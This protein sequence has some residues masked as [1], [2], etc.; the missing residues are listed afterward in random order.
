MDKVITEPKKRGQT[1]AWRI[2]RVYRALWEKDM[3]NDM[4]KL[5]DYAIDSDILPL[6]DKTD[7]RVKLETLL[8]RMITQNEFR[9]LRRL[10]WDMIYIKNSHPVILNQL[11]SAGDDIFSM[12]LDAVVIS[13]QSRR[14]KHSQTGQSLSF[15]LLIPEIGKNAAFET[16]EDITVAEFSK[17]HLE[18][19]QFYSTFNR[20]RGVK[21]RRMIRNMDGLN[22]NDISFLFRTVHDLKI[23]RRSVD[24]QRFST[25][26]TVSMESDSLQLGTYFLLLGTISGFRWLVDQP[27]MSGTKKA[28]ITD[29]TGTLDFRI[30]DKFLLNSSKGVLNPLIESFFGL[31]VET[32]K[33]R[34]ETDYNGYAL[35]LGYWSLDE[36]PYV[37]KIIPLGEN[38]STENM[39]RFYRKAYLNFRRKARTEVMELLFG[40]PRNPLDE[41]YSADKK[42]A[43]AKEGSWD[44]TSFLKFVNSK[45][46]FDRNSKPDQN[47]EK[48]LGYMF[49]NLDHL[50]FYRSEEVEKKIAHHY[51]LPSGFTC[52]KCGSEIY[53]VSPIT[54]CNL[55]S[56]EGNQISIMMKNS[57]NADSTFLSQSLLILREKIEKLSNCDDLGNFSELFANFGITNLRVGSYDLNKNKIS[58]A[59]TSIIN[60]LDAITGVMINNAV[61]PLAQV[62]PELVN[63]PMQP[64]RL[65][66][67]FGKF[68][69]KAPAVADK[70]LRLINQEKVALVSDQNK[71]YIHLRRGCPLGHQ[72]QDI[73]ENNTSGLLDM[74][75]KELMTLKLSEYQKIQDVYYQQFVQMANSWANTTNE[76]IMRKILATEEQK[77]EVDLKFNVIVK[78]LEKHNLIDEN[79]NPLDMS[80]LLAINTKDVVFLNVCRQIKNG[81]IPQYRFWTHVTKFIMDVKSTSSEYDV[82]HLGVVLGP[83]VLLRMAAL[84]Y[85]EFNYDMI[86]GK[87]SASYDIENKFYENIVRPILKKAIDMDTKRHNAYKSLRT[88]DLSRRT[89]GLL[90]TKIMSGDI[91]T[92]NGADQYIEKIS[93]KL[94]ETLPK[95]IIKSK[96]ILQTY[97]KQDGGKFYV[98][99]KKAINEKNMIST[100]GVKPIQLSAPK[101]VST[102]NISKQ[103]Q[104]HMIQLHNSWK[105]LQE[106]K[107]KTAY[108][109]LYIES[110][111]K[112]QSE[113][114]NL[115]SI[116]MRIMP[117]FKKLQGAN[118]DWSITK[119]FFKS[120]NNLD[121][122]SQENIK[123]M[124][125]KI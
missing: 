17:F 3:R 111:K 75:S 44:K 31:P 16:S 88:V 66:F 89:F 39:S 33:Q 5:V 83:R 52:P 68:G 86:L 14:W 1:V 79:G 81:K 80:H 113:F 118:A 91:Y 34:I 47:L 9:S 12:D 115:I 73:A 103:F 28:Q 61:I 119:K 72:I 96:K 26:S 109:L 38:L 49:I 32:T 63:G 42:W 110:K 69:S 7:G 4:Q 59:A 76:L 114:D 45:F 2:Y 124:L 62:T 107:A 35:I 65:V 84:K 55:L 46:T 82:M 51:H 92:L 99:D 87:S 53:S 122:Y 27:E 125:E 11:I 18:N 70:T 36:D 30:E 25:V 23:I 85:V 57:E 100:K 117:S 95:K 93:L 74:I 116:L 13:A 15:N 22:L 106:S 64:I 123:I 102:E 58:D 56:S 121:S 24:L 90:C 50:A 19:I 60:A 104:G 94:G 78:A 21:S 20:I 120:I 6:V 112:F 97:Q 29:L 71:M 77:K 108:P 10:L 41:A 40:N 54:I 105:R 101:L 43:F 48:I 8:E 98:G 37:I 67:D